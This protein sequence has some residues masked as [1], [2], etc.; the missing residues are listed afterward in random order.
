LGG[1][2]VGG[3]NFWDIVLAVG[4]MDNRLRYLSYS[5]MISTLGI[6]ASSNEVTV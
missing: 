5:A 2:V 3:T 4:S 1:D 6:E